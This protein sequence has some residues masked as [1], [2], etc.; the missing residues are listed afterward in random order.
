MK[1]LATIMLRKIQLC[2]LVNEVENIPNNFVDLP[3]PGYTHCD[4]ISVYEPSSHQS[5]NIEA[6]D[7][8]PSE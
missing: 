7:L 6:N 8:P 2:L 1:R 4:E 3:S 5:D